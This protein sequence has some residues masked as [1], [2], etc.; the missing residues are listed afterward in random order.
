LA[1]STFRNGQ[2]YVVE[3]SV[4]IS[5][6]PSPGVVWF[7][8][9]ANATESVVVTPLHQG[10]SDR[11]PL[12]SS[13]P[14]GFIMFPVAAEG[15]IRYRM[16][17]TIDFMTSSLTYTEVS[18]VFPST[19]D[20][21]VGGNCT[22]ATS[23]IPGQTFNMDPSVD[24]LRDYIRATYR[25]YPGVERLAVIFT[26]DCNGF[27]NAKLYWNEFVL[28]PGGVFNSNVPFNIINPSPG[29]YDTGVHLF[30][31]SIIYDH[32]LTLYITTHYGKKGFVPQRLDNPIWKMYNDI[33]GTLRDIPI[34]FALGTITRDPCSAIVFS[35]YIF[36][37]E[38][39]SPVSYLIPDFGRTIGFTRMFP[40]TRQPMDCC[41]CLNGYRI[42]SLS[43]SLANKTLINTQSMYSSNQY[44][45]HN[46]QCTREIR[47]D[48]VYGPRTPSNTTNQPDCLVV[49]NVNVTVLGN[50][51]MIPKPSYVNLG[52]SIVFTSANT[53]ITHRIIAGE[54]GD[55]T[56]NNPQLIPATLLPYT[57]HVSNTTGWGTITQFTIHA[58]TSPFYET[59]CFQP[60]N[61]QSITANIYVNTQC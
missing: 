56:P 32:D 10:R 45:E 59:L 6:G 38:W 60:T 21:T 14:C 36:N 11:G 16:C 40:N 18:A 49:K 29:N 52:D 51:I 34:S 17:E 23:C 22:S 19:W 58:S 20:T 61:F 43:Y 30:A 41:G 31:P 50:G 15:I 37:K 48:C 3:R 42:E 33:P 8:S 44:C 47:L 2:C 54:C 57:L 13:A 35:P 28:L 4:I 9:G 39:A 26:A 1:N 25:Y 7:P 53:S 5:G 55:T 24:P 27:A 46:I 12:F